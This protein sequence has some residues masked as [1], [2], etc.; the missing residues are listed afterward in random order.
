MAYT[1][2]VLMKGTLIKSIVWNVAALACVVGLSCTGGEGCE[3]M[4]AVFWFQLVVQ[5]LANE[6]WLH[7]SA[8]PMLL[9]GMFGMLRKRKE[10]D[11]ER[12]MQRLLRLTSV[13]LVAAPAVLYMVL[14]LLQGVIGE[15]VL[16]EFGLVLSGALYMRSL[17]GLLLL[18]LVS[19]VSGLLPLGPSLFFGVL[20]SEQ[21]FPDQYPAADL[22]PVVVPVEP[23]PSVAPPGGIEVLH[24]RRAE[25]HLCAVR[26]MLADGEEILLATAPEPYNSAVYQPMTQVV[27]WIFALLG[28][29]LLLNGVGLAVDGGATPWGV[30]AFLVPGGICLLVSVPGLLAV[31]R[32]RR[33]LAQTD[34][35]ITNCRLFIMAPGAVRQFA[36]DSPLELQLCMR[37]STRG[38]VLLSEPTLLSRGVK[39]LFGKSA[40]AAPSVTMQSNH[41]E[42]LQGLINIPSAPQVYE[43]IR[44]LCGKTE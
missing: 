6:L 15:W 14:A 44:T 20:D 5:V 37:S 39:A 31:P 7:S 16:R 18:W 38:D 13:I 30:I 11:N 2:R 40:V 29:C 8:L 32:Y 34:F 43:L 27:L 9:L 25:E 4:A 42:Q 41:G 3:Q 26:R 28:G 22:P 23:A 35:I 21:D 10:S 12:S 1:D 19:L 33:R 24:S 36:W 17:A